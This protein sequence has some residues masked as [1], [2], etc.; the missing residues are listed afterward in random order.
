MNDKAE[1]SWQLEDYRRKDV[2]APE[3]LEGQPLSCEGELMTDEEVAQYIADAISTLKIL[4]DRNSSRFEEVQEAFF[5]DLM[6]L[7]SIDRL[8]VEEYTEIT[9]QETYEF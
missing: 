9:K 2:E 4:N 8:T 5:A 6:F 7:L 1:L 3:R